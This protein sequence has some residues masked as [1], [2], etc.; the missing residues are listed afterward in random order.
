MVSDVL[1]PAAVSLGASAFF[2]GIIVLPFV[3]N[4]SEYFSAI[5]FA[6]RDRMGLALGITV[7]ST[8]QIVLLTAPILVLLS[9]VLRHPMN[10]IFS[11]PLELVAIAATAFAVN[12]VA[13]DGE[14]TRFEG[15]T[16]AGGLCAVGAGVFLLFDL[17]I[18]LD[19]LRQN[20]L[21]YG[22]QT[23]AVIRAVD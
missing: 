4:A 14:T 19:S 12:S 23:N 17:T 15:S 11:N 22:A 8:I 21:L 1:E 16:V 9:Y 5:H 2:L 10:L 13:Q 7:G 18:T 6:R 3:G 20:I